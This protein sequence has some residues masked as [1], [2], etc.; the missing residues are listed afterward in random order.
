[1]GWDKGG[2]L[3]EEE[4][5]IFCRLEHGGEGLEWELESS[6]ADKGKSQLLS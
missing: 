1:M 6:A 4:C 2:G 5:V 3:V